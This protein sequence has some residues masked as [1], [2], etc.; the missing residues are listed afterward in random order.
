MRS[1]LEKG[2]MPMNLETTNMLLA[3]LKAWLGASLLLAI[4]WS[5]LAIY[6]A[7]KE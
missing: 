4:L 1:Q 5:A 7:G 2:V 6:K 3:G